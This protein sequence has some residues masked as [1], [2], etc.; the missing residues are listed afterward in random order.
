VGI[1]TPGKVVI[2]ANVKDDSQS[3]KVIEEA[4]K[5]AVATGKDVKVSTNWLGDAK[6]SEQSGW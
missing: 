6:W 4:K 2:D 1:F 3:R 5:H